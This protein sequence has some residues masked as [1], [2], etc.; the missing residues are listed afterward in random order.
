[1]FFYRLGIDIGE[2]SIGWFILKLNE[3]MEVCDIVDGGVYIFPD[4]REAESSRKPL[5]VSRRMA[6]G[7][8]RNND[9]K[10]SRKRR[11]IRLLVETGIWPKSVEEQKKL[12]SLDPFVLRQKAVNEKISLPEL[13]RALFHLNQGRGFKSNRKS[14]GKANENGKIKLAVQAL[15]TQLA[16]QKC[17]T[18]GEYLYRRHEKRVSTKVRPMADSKGYEFYPTREMSEAEFDL[19]MARQQQYYPE[20]ITEVVAALR[21][22]IFFQRSLRPQAVGKC[23]F[24]LQEYRAPVWHPLFQ[25]FRMLQEV[26]NLDLVKATKEEVG[27][28][29]E[30]KKKILLMLEDGACLN[31]KGI[32]LFSK[33]RKKLDIPS[34]RKFNLQSDKRDGLQGDWAVWKLADE[35]CFGKSWF[36]MLPEKQLEVLELLQGAEDNVELKQKLIE[37]FGLDDSH[38]EKVTQVNLPDGYASLSLKAIKNI[39]PY[40]EQGKVYSE[41]CALAGYNH[42]DRRTG[43]IYDYLP[44]YGRILKSAVIGGRFEGEEPDVDEDIGLQEVYFGKI[45][46]MREMFFI[47]LNGRKE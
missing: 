29:A 4:G 34:T 46:K 14:D 44:Y 28:T 11:L 26:N 38:A 22:T 30:Q 47:R 17:Q 45:M 18:Y 21:D 15:E 33:I 35:G 20:L 40:L 42:S 19:I 1:M 39:L 7:I 5:S 31:S 6:R 32:L 25:R 37:Q 3:R 9:R 36:K 13:G 16:E 8:R 2:T 12:E 10:K 43:E 23:E 24:E 27:L 41:A